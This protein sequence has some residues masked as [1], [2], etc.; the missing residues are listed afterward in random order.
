[1]TNNTVLQITPRE[2]SS[3]LR[4]K[5]EETFRASAKCR[6]QAGTAVFYH[7]NSSSFEQLDV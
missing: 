6:D 2:H 1:M 5:T 3:D 4:D 7:K